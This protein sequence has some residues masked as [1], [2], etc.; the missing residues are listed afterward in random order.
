MTETTGL[1]PEEEQRWERGEARLRAI[2]GPHGLE[3]LGWLRD[4]SEEMLR[5]VVEFAYGEVLARPA[6]DLRSRQLCTIAM[7]AALGRERQLR[8][9]IRNG[10]RVG[11]SKEEIIEALIQVAIYAGF[12]AA[13]SALAEARAVFAERT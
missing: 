8:A 11:L 5:Y 12:P 7:L 4:V 13:M 9:H 2:T 6:L 10:L 1:S 3:R